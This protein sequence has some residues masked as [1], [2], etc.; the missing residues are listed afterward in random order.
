MDKTL[1]D[2]AKLSMEKRTKHSREVLEN[3]NEWLSRT[4]DD[5]AAGE[6]TA[7]DRTEE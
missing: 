7:R 4:D 6:G 5:L 1:I 2:I 3:V